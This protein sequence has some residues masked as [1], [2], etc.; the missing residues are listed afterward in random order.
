MAYG[1]SKLCSAAA[2]ALSGLIV[3]VRLPVQFLA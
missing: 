3:P 2:T 1:T